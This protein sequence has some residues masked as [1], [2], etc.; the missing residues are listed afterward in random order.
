VSLDDVRF[1]VGDALE[2]AIDVDGEAFALRRFAIDV[3]AA[4]LDRR[5]VRRRLD[6]LVDVLQRV[7]G[8]RVR[9]RQGLRILDQRF[10]VRFDVE[11]RQHV[12]AVERADRGIGIGRRRVCAHG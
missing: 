4:D 7:D 9:A 6:Q 2:D 8:P 5:L 10:L 12:G 1:E 3:D 11:H